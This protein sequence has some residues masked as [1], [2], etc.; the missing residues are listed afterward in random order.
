MYYFFPSI[1]YLRLSSKFGIHLFKALI[2]II[3]QQ[4]NFL[5]KILSDCQPCGGD[6]VGG[7]SSD[8]R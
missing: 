8:V 1:F 7:G 2:Q 3:L 5:Q 6:D 4:S